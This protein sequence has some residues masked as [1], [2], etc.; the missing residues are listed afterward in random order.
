MTRSVSTTHKVA[1][2]KSTIVARLPEACRD[3]ERAA[4]FIEDMR[5][6]GNPCCPRCG[7]FNVRGP[8]YTNTVEGFFALLKRGIMGTFHSVSKK[9]LHR[10][11]TEFEFRYNHRN[12][13]DGERTRAAI[14][15]AE[16]KRLRYRPS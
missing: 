4:E 1:D 2:D 12:V 7:D 13:D 9:H 5:W 11:V 14:K 6:G 15:G 10:Y 16:W 8:V 3:E